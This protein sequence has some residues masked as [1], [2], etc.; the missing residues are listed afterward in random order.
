[1]NDKQKQAMSLSIKKSKIH[2]NNLTHI[3]INK[4][5]KNNIDVKYIDL[6]HNYIASAPITCRLKSIDKNS[7]SIFKNFIEESIIKNRFDDKTI[8]ELKLDTYFTYRFNKESKI[9]NKIYDDSNPSNRVKYGSINVKNKIEGDEL[10]AS[11]GDFS[12]FM[13][14][15]IKDRC[16]FTYGNSEES[17]WYICTYKH[18]THLLYH[19]PIEDINLIIDLINNNLNIKKMITYIEIQFHG[20]INIVTDI[21]KFTL[22]SELYDLHK[23]DIIKI[24]EIYPHIIFEIY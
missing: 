1:M 7:K 15:S 11:Y 22:P 23:N 2:E 12:V 19:M 10:A 5:I 3:I 9:F 8:D 21:N 24:Q 20:D 16:T 13:N 18:F 17:M 4:F 6:I 14:E